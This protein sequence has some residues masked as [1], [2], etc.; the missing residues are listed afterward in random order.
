MAPKGLRR[1]AAAAGAG[2]PVH[3]MGRRVR[4]GDPVMR[5]PAA[6]VGGDRHPEK[7][8]EGSFLVGE[9]AH[10]YGQKG[11]VAGQVVEEKAEEGRRM[12]TM[13]LTG[14]TCIL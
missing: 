12:V 8:E 3:G 13:N 7:V 1:P 2:V 11:A 5:R 4:G 10:Y 14:T 6:V 9:E